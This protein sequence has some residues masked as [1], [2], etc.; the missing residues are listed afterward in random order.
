MLNPGLPIEMTGSHGFAFI[1]GKK[2]VKLPDDI[3]LSL[4]RPPPLHDFPDPRNGL[5]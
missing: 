4:R 1:F 2:P 5:R 3:L